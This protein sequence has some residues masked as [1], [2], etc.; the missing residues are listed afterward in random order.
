MATI[1]LPVSF[2]FFL[3]IHQTLRLDMMQGESAI[4]QNYFAHFLHLILPLEGVPNNSS[5]PNIE[6]HEATSEFMAKQS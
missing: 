1:I 6:W 5:I 2:I 3:L 4:P